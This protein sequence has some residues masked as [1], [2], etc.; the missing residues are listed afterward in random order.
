MPSA[1]RNMNAKIGQRFVDALV[2]DHVPEEQDEI[3]SVP[4][5]ERSRRR[6]APAARRSPASRMARINKI[7]TKRERHDQP[8]SR[9]D[10]WSKSYWIGGS[11]AD[12]ARTPGS[13]ASQAVA[14]LGD[15]VER[16]FV[17]GSSLKIDVE[18]SRP[19]VTRAPPRRRS[20]R[21]HAGTPSA[22]AATASTSAGRT[23]PFSRSTSTVVGASVPAGSACS[24]DLE[25]VHALG[26]LLEEVRGAVV[27]LVGE[28]AERADPEHSGR[29]RQ[30]QPGPPQ[31]AV[32]EAPP[33]P[34]ALGRPPPGRRRPTARRGQNA[35]RPPIVEHRR[36]QR[37]AGEPARMRRRLP[38]P[39]RATGSTRSRRPAAPASIARPSARSPG[40]RGPSG[41]ARAASRRACP[42][43]FAAPRGSGTPVA[44]SS[45][46]P[47]R[48]SA[49]PGCS[50]SWR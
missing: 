20:T 23:G 11:S 26:L 1:T 5:N 37:E 16:A 36:Q 41:R 18:A 39:A 28:Q 46:S 9:A 47:R 6:S 29:H 31:H 21:R 15:D 32:A 3:P 17:K 13:Q 44:G 43:I 22:A 50:S 30:R 7:T 42:P 2:S 14:Q 49:R 40:S 8:R 19:A 34:G 27:L 24:S 48:T 33:P 38:P 12:E 4:K 45:R 35:R 25:A 10:A